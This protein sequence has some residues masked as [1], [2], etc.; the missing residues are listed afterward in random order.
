M[1]SFERVMICPLWVKRPCWASSWRLGVWMPEL[2][3][4]QEWDQFA[5]ENKENLPDW[6]GWATQL[7]RFWMAWHCM[8]Q[9]AHCFAENVQ[10]EMFVGYCP[11]CPCA[12]WNLW[13]ALTQGS[14]SCTTFNNGTGV[15][16]SQ[17]KHMNYWWNSP[18]GMHLMT[19]KC[20]VLTCDVL[21]LLRTAN[22][23]SKLDHQ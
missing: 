8:G 1:S 7:Q 17:W 21:F 10:T 13:L 4:I 23:F 12:A 22:T 14:L 3:G 15:Q 20:W 9:L 16:I 19:L 5:N 11:S 18:H 6:C 2:A